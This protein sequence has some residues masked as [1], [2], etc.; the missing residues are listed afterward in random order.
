MQLGG[1]R[2]LIEFPLTTAKIAGYK[3]PVAGGGYFRI[4]PYSLTRWALKS[5]NLEGKPFIFYLHPWE[6]DPGQPRIKTSLLSRFRHYTNLD[7]CGDRLQ[8]LLQQFRFGSVE[9]VLDKSGLLALS[10]P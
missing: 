10:T 6:L 8:K 4:F 5:V 9:Q 2:S 1:G 7:V 3:L